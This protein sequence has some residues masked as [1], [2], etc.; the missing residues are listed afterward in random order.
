MRIG[1]DKILELYFWMIGLLTIIVAIFSVGFPV[2]DSWQVV[3]ATASQSAGK[4]NDQT[5][6]NESVIQSLE[7]LSSQ[8]QPHNAPLCRH[9]LSSSLFYV[10]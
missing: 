9:N 1:I 8:D 7:V 5:K 4:E 10:E 2:T 6:A 3:N